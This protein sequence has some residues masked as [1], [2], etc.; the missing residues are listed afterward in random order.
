MDTYNR[1][2]KEQQDKREAQRNKD[3]AIVEAMFSNNPR[4]LNNAYL[5][6]REEN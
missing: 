4:P 3:K 1:I 6:A 2:L 5:L